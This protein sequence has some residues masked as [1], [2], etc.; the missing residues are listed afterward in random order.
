[1]KS[2]DCPRETEVA[3]WVARELPPDERADFQR[4]LTGCG[5]CQASV[6]STRRVVDRL[7]ATRAPV[8]QRDLAP[9]ILARLSARP[10]NI[11][12]IGRRWRQKLT[13]A[14]AVAALLSAVALFVH[15][16]QIPAG[17]GP[18]VIAAGPVPPT[19]VSPADMDAAN[20]SR[21]LDWF[22]LHQEID[23][24][25]EPAK[26]GGHTQFRPALTALPLIALLEGSSR[27]QHAAAAERALACLRREQNSD[28]SFGKGSYNHGISTLALL[29]SLQAKPETELRQ[30]AAAALNVALSRQTA[31]GGWGDSL[32][33]DV[34][35]TLW[36]REALELA[37]QLGWQEA[38]PA[39]SKADHW[40]ASQISSAVPAT[41]SETADADYLSSYFAVVKLHRLGTPE[42]SAHLS[43]I[44]RQLMASQSLAGEHPGSWDPTD[45]WSRA[46]GRLYSTA[47]ASLALR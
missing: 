42:A 1:M 32:N 29:H 37:V 40:L 44:R 26:W 47:L 27:P 10:D 15:L 4:H 21:A 43:T 6:E 24:S 38:V 23:G 2:T 34:S 9:A 13:A 3:A 25:W 36:H 41:D 31:A 19:V 14:A 39:L 11:L 5:A 46:G 45:Q 8:A 20:V 12:Q 7:L 22:C 30:A 35:T 17:S 18:S 33:A 28:G 16:K